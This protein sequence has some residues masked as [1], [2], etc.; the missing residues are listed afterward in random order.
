MKCPWTYNAKKNMQEFHDKVW[1]K[2]IHEEKEMFRRLCLLTF[3]CGLKWQVILDKEKIL[4]T[5]F[6]DFD[7][8]I[9]A[10]FDQNDPYFQ[11]KIPG[12]INNQRKIKAVLDNAKNLIRLHQNGYTLEKI[13]WECTNNRIINN[14]WTN[15]FQ[16][17]T[18][19]EL[20]RFLAKKMKQ[21]GFCFVGPKSMYAYLQMVGVINDHL[22]GCENK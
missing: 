15:E 7:A 10:N 3:Q 22:V 16:I 1:C 4:N 12:S 9:L 18:E 11:K 5:I 21:A 20:S 14:Q 19:S 6:F 13:V 2:P 17:P 8:Q